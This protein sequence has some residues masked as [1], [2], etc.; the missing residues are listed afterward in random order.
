MEKSIGES[1]ASTS[2]PKNGRG[3]R[4]EGFGDDAKPGNA[5]LRLFSLL[6][7]KSQNGSSKYSLKVVAE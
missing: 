1:F 3:R 6:G 2:H 4:R 5:I 7:K